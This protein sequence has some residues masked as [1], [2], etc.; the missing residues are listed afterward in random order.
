MSISGQRTH[1]QLVTVGDF[2][3][4]PVIPPTSE[5]SIP[6]PL[7]EPEVAS[8]LLVAQP[9]SAIRTLK[10]TWRRSLTR[11]TADVQRCVDQ[12]TTG[13]LERVSVAVNIDRGGRVFAH[14]ADAPDT[15]LSRCLAASLRET[16]LPAP[17]EPVSLV[18]VFT[19]RATPRRP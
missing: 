14:V 6:T 8:E 3:I 10:A 7:V 16:P 11:R 1:L 17:R 19:L 2:V 5:I 15:P 18:H 13:S 9:P 4:G 12:T